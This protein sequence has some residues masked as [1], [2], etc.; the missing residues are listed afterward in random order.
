MPRHNFFVLVAIAVVSVVCFRQADS[1]HRTEYG[2]MFDT[3]TEVLNKVDKHY[4]RKVDNRL[5]FEGALQGMMAKLDPYSAYIDPDHLKEFKASLEQ[6]FGG[7]GIEVARDPQTN[8][9]TIT[10]P[11]A[12]SPAYKQGIRAGDTIV[13]I[14]G[15]NAEAISM[16]EI[17]GRLRGKEGETVRLTVLHKGDTEP[18]EIAIQRAVIPVPAVL[19]DVR[20]ADNHWN[21]FLAGHEGIG[22][23]RVTNFGENTEKELKA[24]L[25]WLAERHVQGLILDLRNNQGGLL[26]EATKT[27]DLFLE[28]GRIVSTRG[29]EGV[30]TKTWDASGGAP[31]AQ[32]PMVVLVNQFTAS[33]SEIVAACLQDHHRAIIVGQRTWG[34]GTVQNVIPLEHGRSLLKLTTASYWR[35]NGQDIHRYPDDKDQEDWGVQPDS[36]YEMKLSDAELATV[37]Q[38]RRQRDVIAEREPTPEDPD[39]AD[40]APADVDP[41]LQKA[42][43]ALQSLLPK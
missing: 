15:K 34:K 23:V 42:L 3:F 10:S 39:A 37:M 2:E 1:A 16:Q 30:E 14:D 22:Y 6:K 17:V 32:L 27:C 12:D 25:A 20:D 31:Y 24:A 4:L 18:V 19:G 5:L 29:R 33:A 35:P 13:K 7:I 8:R 38:H 11:M 9:L 28:H 43:E 21:F 36:G 26:D 40:K 41:Q